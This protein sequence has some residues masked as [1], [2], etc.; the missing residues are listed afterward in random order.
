MDRQRLATHKRNNI[1][2]SLLLLVAMTAILGLLGWIVTGPDGLVWSFLLGLV[3]LVLGPKLSPHLVL[4]MY[5]AQP[6]SPQQA[7]DLYAVLKTLAERAGLPATPRLFYVPTRVLNAFAVGNRNGSA[8]ALT[9]GLLRTL[10]LRE[11]VGVIAHELSHVRNNDTWVMGLADVVTRLTI[12]LSQ[13]GLLLVI[14]GLPLM[15]MGGVDL[16]LVPVLVLL[17]APSISTLLQLALSRTREY[18]ADLGAVE[19]T[20]DP[21]GLA[22][23]LEKIERYQG[24]WLESILMPG[25][26]VPDPGMLRTH[27]H[28][29]E[30]VNRLLSLT[31][32]QYGNTPRLEV[33]RDA[34]RL[35]NSL[36]L[37]MR[38]PSWHW[39]GL[40]H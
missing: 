30:R 14:V 9:D 29:Q 31:P 33:K 22:S 7:P 19:L 23:A 8:I 28:T 35:L 32:E 2:Q 13:V 26:K 27:P 34:T 11:L 36:P 40:W 3:I 15:L 24:G 25:R 16:P 4:R 38:R 20:G 37:I 39:N 1:A 6:I 10:K 12:A 18:D 21:Q 5:R 17:L